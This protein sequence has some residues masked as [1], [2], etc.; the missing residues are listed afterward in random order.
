MEM[1]SIKDCTVM[2]KVNGGIAYLKDI[3]PKYFI[4]ALVN[5][6]VNILMTIQGAINLAGILANMAEAAT[7][8]IED[9]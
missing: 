3:E 1:I 2:T 7:D 4:C 6:E 5:D 8:L 9:E